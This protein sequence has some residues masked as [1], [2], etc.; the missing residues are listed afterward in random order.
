M[1][2]KYKK[3]FDIEIIMMLFILSSGVL[4][5]FAPILSI[6]CMGIALMIISLMLFYQNKIKKI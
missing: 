3:F 2:S 6:N 1:H 5:L 4:L